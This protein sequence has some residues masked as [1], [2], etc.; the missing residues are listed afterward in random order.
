MI[1]TNSREG[2]GKIR[3]KVLIRKG[4]SINPI[5]DG[6]ETGLQTNTVSVDTKGL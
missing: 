6:S 1:K 4:R 3:K 5:T 2:G